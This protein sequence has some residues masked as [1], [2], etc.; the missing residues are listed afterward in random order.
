[1]KK[2]KKNKFDKFLCVFFDT[3]GGCKMKLN[4]LETCEEYTPRNHPL[5]S[6]RLRQYYEKKELLSN[7]KY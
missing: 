3:C 4:C 1:M 5:A 7:R 6:L 2:Q